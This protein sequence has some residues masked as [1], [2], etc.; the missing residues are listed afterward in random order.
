M[1][2][3]LFYFIMLIRSDRSTWQDGSP[4]RCSGGCSR[5]R[6]RYRELQLF[7]PIAEDWTGLVYLFTFGE[8]HCV[9]VVCQTLSGVHRK[10]L[11][12]ICALPR[13]RIGS[14]KPSPAA[15]IRAAFIF[16]S[17][18]LLCNIQKDQI[19]NGIW[20]FWYTGRDSNPQPSEPESDALSIEP[21][22][23]LP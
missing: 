17:L 21:P 20:S 14:V 1:S 13:L 11:V 16:S 12:C 5:S 9:A 18:F 4:S 22:V 3:W 7:C 6:R 8:N 19:P 2:G 15:L 10:G 23:H